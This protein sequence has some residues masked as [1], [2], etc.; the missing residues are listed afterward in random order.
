MVRR[1]GPAG[2]LHY[3]QQTCITPPPTRGRSFASI[4]TTRL[5]SVSPLTFITRY[6]V[7]ACAGAH[8]LAVNHAELM[9]I[10]CGSCW[11]LAWQLDP[12]QRLVCSVQRC[13]LSARPRRLPHPPACRARMSQHPS[14]QPV[15]RAITSPHLTVCTP[16]A[17]RTRLLSCAC[18]HLEIARCSRRLAAGA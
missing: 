9:S 15:L 14:S 17:R 2:W 8:C 4:P 18:G 7:R 10:S 13:A 16:P 6:Q 5:P 11:I 1:I 12:L 3:Y